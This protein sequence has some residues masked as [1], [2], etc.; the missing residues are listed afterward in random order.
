MRLITYE[1]I[2]LLKYMKFLNIYNVANRKRNAIL[3]Y[4]MAFNAFNQ[5]IS[6]PWSIFFSSDIYW[7]VIKLYRT[8]YIEIQTLQ[9]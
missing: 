6:F 5:E 9:K 3:K 8:L 7:M 4:T 2:I 1:S